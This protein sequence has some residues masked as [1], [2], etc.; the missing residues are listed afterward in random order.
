MMKLFISGHTGMVGSALVRR[1][2]K[3]AGVSIVTRS[4]QELNL[5]DQAAVAADLDQVRVS[6]V[7]EV[8]RNYIDL[9]SYRRRL[10]IAR[11]NLASQSETLQIVAWRYQAGLAASTDVEQARTSR[12][13]TRAGIPDLE[14]GQVAAENRLA[15]LLGSSPGSLR[16]MLAGDR[17]F[18]P[19]PASVS[20]ATVPLGLLQVM[21]T[22]TLMPKISAQVA[23]VARA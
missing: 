10:S 21:A 3:V 4:R 14:V 18:P 12:E 17:P 19:V 5:S 9:L 7:A 6:L 2:Q 16:V 1:F 13:Q 22:D 11:D 23:A 20:W 8:A 15:V